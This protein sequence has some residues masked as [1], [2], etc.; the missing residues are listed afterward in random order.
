MLTFVRSMSRKH[1]KDSQDDEAICAFAL[2]FRHLEFYTSPAALL[3]KHSSK[4]AKLILAVPASLSHGPSRALF[5]DFASIPGSV[6]TPLTRR[7]AEGSLGRVLFDKWNSSQRA[8]DKRDK[9]K[10]GSNVMLDGNMVLR[11]ST[12]RLPLNLF[13]NERGVVG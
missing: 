11:V 3:A 6:V 13:S 2:R 10:I 1:K 4:D 8:D 12:S 5:A 9:G 7:G